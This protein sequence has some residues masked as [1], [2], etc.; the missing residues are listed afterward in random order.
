MLCLFLK[1]MVQLIYAPF[2]P[3]NVKGH[4]CEVGSEECLDLSDLVE[5]ERVACPPDL[6]GTAELI[7]GKLA[8]KNFGTDVSNLPKPQNRLFMR[9]AEGHVVYTFLDEY[10]VNGNARRIRAECITTDA[11]VETV[12]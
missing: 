7:M 6:S 5:I 11:V 1:S 3:M 12:V 2:P 9:W 8:I 10:Y 4:V